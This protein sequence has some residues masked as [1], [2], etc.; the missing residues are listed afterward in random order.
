MCAFICVLSYV[1]ASCALIY[2]FSSVCCP[3]CAPIVLSYMCF[4][5]CVLICVLSHVCSPVCSDLCAFLL[6][7]PSPNSTHN[8]VGVSCRDNCYCFRFCC[9]P[10]IAG[11]QPPAPDRSG[12]CRTSCMPC[13]HR[14]GHRQTSTSCVRKGR[15]STGDV[16]VAVGT[17]GPPRPERLADR[18]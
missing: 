14:S 9:S 13:P 11:P 18:P 3:L 8:T 12:H 2:M 16:R 1:C 17:A 5:M 4:Y 6:L 10:P 15:T 7:C